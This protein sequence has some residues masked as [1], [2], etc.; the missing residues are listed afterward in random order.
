MWK[1]EEVGVSGHHQLWP[2]LHREVGPYGKT[3]SG[4]CSGEAVPLPGPRGP[5][6]EGSRFPELL[7]I[8]RSAS[9]RDA[10]THRAADTCRSGHPSRSASAAVRPC[11][12]FRVCL[13]SR[14]R[15]PGAKGARGPL[16]C[17][18][19]PAQGCSCQ[20]VSEN[21]SVVGRGR[22]SQQNHWLI[23]GCVD[24]QHPTL[25]DSCLLGPLL[26]LPPRI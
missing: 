6:R 5:P 2:T 18:R 14:L 20:D 23:W 4:L 21:E 10:T 12:G 11:S 15:A 26:L 8:L 24:R 13:P 1:H 16:L 22:G 3:V 19:C 7:G 17:V 25:M 9:A